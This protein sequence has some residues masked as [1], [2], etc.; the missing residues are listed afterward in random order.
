MGSPRLCKSSIQL[1][2]DDYKGRAVFPPCYLTWG[3]TMVELMKIMVTSFKRSHQALLH[4]V[5][6]TLQQATADSHLC[7]RLLDTHGQVW[8]SLLWGHCSFLLGPGAQG[9][10]CAL[11]ESVSPVLCKFWC[12]YDGI[13]GDLLQEVL[14]HT[15]VYCTQNPCPWAVHCWPVPPQETL[16][17]RS[18][19]VSE[20]SPD[21]HKVCLST[22]SLSGRYGIWF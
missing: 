14:C 10:V 1:S 4:S 18:V 13:N 2:V 3:L 6:P 20:G 9:S 17:H 12:L 11:Q 22:L 16:K 21:V 19:S 15:Q 8:V 5:A 7:Q